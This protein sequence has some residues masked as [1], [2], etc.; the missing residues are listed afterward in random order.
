M[1]EHVVFSVGRTN[2]SKS[3]YIWWFY[4]P[5]FTVTALWL[6]NNKHLLTLIC[7]GLITEGRSNLGFGDDLLAV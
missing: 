5:R 1:R 7:H 6:K 4:L 3:M 2:A